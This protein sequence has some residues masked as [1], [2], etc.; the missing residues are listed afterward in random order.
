MSLKIIEYD[1]EEELKKEIRN[2]QNGRYQFRLNAIVLIKER[3]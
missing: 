2:T 1:T 3:T